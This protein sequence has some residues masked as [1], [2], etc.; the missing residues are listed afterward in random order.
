MVGAKALRE[1]A[2]VAGAA[3][4]AA[5][6]AAL[7]ISGKAALLVLVGAVGLILSLARPHLALGFLFVSKP[8]LD[9]LWAETLGP[10]KLLHL[11]GFLVILW[12]LGL[13]AYLRPKLGEYRFKWL[14]ALWFGLELVQLALAPQDPGVQQLVAR[15]FHGTLFYFLV[16]AVLLDRRQT[17][18]LLWLWA[19]SSLFPAALGLWGLLSGSP[20]FYQVVKEFARLK[21]PYHDA[22]ALATEL[23]PG[24]LIGLYLW[25][26]ER[27]KLKLPA[28]GL[29]LLA[30]FLI[31]RTYTRAYWFAVAAVLALWAARGLRAPLIL[32]VL[33]VGFKWPLIW[34]RLTTAGIADELSGALFGGRWSLWKEGLAI[35]SSLDP[36]SKFFGLGKSAFMSPHNQFLEVLLANGLLGLGLFLVLLGAFLWGLA[37]RLKDALGFLGL[38]ALVFTLIILLAG[39]AI[40]VPNL[41]WLFFG[42]VSLGLHPPERGELGLEPEPQVHEGQAQA[43]GD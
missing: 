24:F 10:L 32:G 1:G 35:F 41:A 27:G 3:A 25:R 4:A 6:L 2:A 19:L 21:G 40:S 7:G 11:V 29:A 37:L 17:R 33:L 12:G 34:K 42:L 28:A 23:T 20:D 22:A 30:G 38:T 15:R 39:Q 5:L 31:F 8:I 18:A 13:L 9:V 26:T 14:V 36:L 43:V 16:P